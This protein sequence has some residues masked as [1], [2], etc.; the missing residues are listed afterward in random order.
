MHLDDTLPRDKRGGH[1]NRPEDLVPL[2]K[3][4]LRPGDV[5]L[6]KASHGQNLGRVVE[7]LTSAADGQVST[8]ERG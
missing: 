5:V 8:A 2:L 1:T 3:S 7:A 4:L 6:V